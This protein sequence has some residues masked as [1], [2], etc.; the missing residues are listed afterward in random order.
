MDDS[1]FC[2]LALIAFLLFLLAMAALNRRKAM[3]S[4]RSRNASRA[5]CDDSYW[6]DSSS[7][8]DMGHGSHGTDHCSSDCGDCGGCD[9]G[10]D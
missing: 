1:L 7:W 3:A 8:G 10:A 4:F 5:A 6:F 2:F 9:G